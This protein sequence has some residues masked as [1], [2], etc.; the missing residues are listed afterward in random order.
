MQVVVSTGAPLPSRL[1]GRAMSLLKSRIPPARLVMIVS[2]GLFTSL[3]PHPAG[4]LDQAT[5]VASGGGER[6]LDRLTAGSLV[7]AAKRDDV[8]DPQDILA[9]AQADYRRMVDLLYASG[10]YSGTVNIRIDGREA[11]EIPPLTPPTRISVAE[12]R[13]NPG[14]RFTFGMAEIGPLA[15]G[16]TPPEEY[17]AGEIARATVIGD[18]AEGAVD[19]WRAAGHPKVG[20]A[21]QQVTANHPEQRLDARIGLAPG[22]V[23]TFGTTTVQEGSAVRATAIRRIA[24]VP[25]GTRYNPEDV[26]KAAQRLRR[27]GAF[28]SVA[29]TEADLLNPDNS[30]DIGITVVDEAPRRYGFGAEVATDTG[31]GLNGFWMHRNVMGG[32]ERFRVEG[33]V[34]GIGTERGGLNYGLSARFDRPAVYGP[35]TGFFAVAGLEQLDEEF[36]RTERAFGGVGVTRTITE[37]LEGEL[38]LRLE[39]SRVAQRFLLLSPDGSTPRRD[40][41]LVTLPGAL[42]WDRRDDI[43]NPTEGFYL[44]AEAMPFIDLDGTDSGGRLRFDAR[45]Y[46]AFGE[47]DGIVLAGRAQVGSVFGPDLLNIRP[48]FLFYSGGGGTVRGQPFQSLFV[49]Q[50]G[51][52]GIGGR[53]FVGFS[54]EVRAKVSQRISLVGFADAGYIGAESLYDGSG[55]WHSGAG[56]G[57]RYDTTVGPIRLDVAGPVSGDTGDGVQIYIGIGQA[58]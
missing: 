50:P 1:K 3:A 13:V 4:A 36:F 5:V 53:S 55:E 28:R 20:I 44:K 14:P 7:I 49:E 54:G 15:S 52:R 35:D 30:L 33:S 23:A 51:V 22:P 18:A 45:L 32:A 17:R 8:T 24:G 19:A 40:F 31:L 10:Y 39:Y 34:Q 16:S 29:L 37:T 38:G 58:F 56:L 26:A 12:I 57:L 21:T 48:D 9:A 11:A 25:E 6:L 2:A 46:Q 42:T 41:T 27:T 43:L 47:N